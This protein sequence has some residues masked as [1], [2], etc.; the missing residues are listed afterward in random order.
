MIGRSV[1]I[2]LV[3]SGLSHGQEKV[4]YDDHVLPVFQAACLNCH[5]PD[6]TKGGLDLSTFAA[7]MRGGSGGAVVEPGDAGSRLV[8]VV[9]QTVEPKM[10]PEGDKLAAEKIEVLVKWIEGGLLEN[11]GSKARKASKPKF[12]ALGSDPTARPEGPPPMPEDLLLEPPVTTGSASAVRALAAS[13]WAPLLAVSSQKQVLLYDTGSL[14]LVGVLPFPEGQP[15]SLT[16]SP[17]GRHVIAAGGV[18]GKSG[19][20]VT[21]DV[22]TGERVLEAGREFDSI[23][24]ADATGGFRSVL[25]G[26]PSRL[27]KFWNTATG[28]ADHSIKKHTD[29]ITALDVSPDGV[30]A[31]SGDR[32]GGVWVWEAD[33]GNEFHTLRAHQAGITALAFRS[34]SNILASASEDGTVR[35]W[36]MNN[37]GE[38]RKIDAHPGGVTAFS[39]ARDG[40]SATAGRDRKLKLWKADFGHERDLAGDLPSLPTAVAIDAEAKR[41]FLGD[42][43]GTVRVYQTEKPG[44]VAELLSN[45]PSIEVRIQRLET[46]IAGAKDAAE[47]SKRNKNESDKALDDVRKSLDEAVSQLRQAE[48]IHKAALGSAESNGQAVAKLAEQA[49]ARLK[50]ARHNV[51][52]RRKALKEAEARSKEAAKQAE[53]AT[54]RIPTLEKDLRH[55]NA[56]TINTL[57]LEADHKALAHRT[58]ADSLRL[59]FTDLA[60][61]VTRQAETVNR[62]RAEAQRLRGFAETLAPDSAEALETRATLSVIDLVIDREEAGLARLEE[63]ISELHRSVDQSAAEAVAWAEQARQRMAEYRKAG[64]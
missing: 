40:R 38:V 9:R 35:F 58:D 22:V 13:P 4:T 43:D 34:D 63:Q 55:W 39:F 6:K 23:L 54:A 5:N 20:T 3:F 50:D 33:T 45:P 24:A 19:V 11:S 17:D 1:A 21:F 18:A 44:Q 48:K 52:D 12:A 31:A 30:L 27:L 47:A 64:E 2:F 57:R 41:V 14:Q 59:D 37:G 15:V 53:S 62:K 42:A 25:T 49:E 46:E 16:F 60:A 36:E 29:W 51:D 56:A 61:A 7:T 26:G 8:A 28:E 32:N 10:P